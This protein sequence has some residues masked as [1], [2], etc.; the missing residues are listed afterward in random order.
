MLKL[1][2]LSTNASAGSHLWTVE[3]CYR[4]AYLDARR[5][6]GARLSATE[7]LQ[8]DLLHHLLDG[9]PESADGRRGHRRFPVLL[10]A[11]VR[12]AEESWAGVVLDLSGHGMFLV[13]QRPVPVGATVQVR[14]GRPGEVVYVFT[15][16]VRR[17]HP[18]DQL[19]GLGLSFCSPPLEMRHARRAA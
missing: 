14:L 17:G 13:T 7:H 15:C 6:C 19:C 1:D 10:Q 9:D 16:T 3:L 5:A 11:T 12:L 2:D 4:Y 18:R 8:L